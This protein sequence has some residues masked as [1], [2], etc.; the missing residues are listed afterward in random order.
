M[1]DPDQGDSGA[2]ISAV[3]PYVL[4]GLSW[5]LATNQVLSR[6]SG[7]DSVG[8]PAPGVPSFE[9]SVAL[10][11][12]AYTLFYTLVLAALFSMAW[13]E[14]EELFGARN[15]V[16]ASVMSGAERSERFAAET[17]DRFG[18]LADDDQL[19]HFLLQSGLVF[20]FGLGTS[21]AFG[22]YL[23]RIRQPKDHKDLRQ[24][25]FYFCCFQLLLAAVV[26]LSYG[27]FVA[28]GAGPEP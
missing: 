15:S 16:G 7:P 3:R 6:N 18:F 4:L 11:Q 20:A 24:K 14:H 10:M 26:M 27:T 13:M 21:F 5:L 2:V 17:M 19:Y 8:P 23:K 22:V 25:V 9:P 12:P 28:P 1:T